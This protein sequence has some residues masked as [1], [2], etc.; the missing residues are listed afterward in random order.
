M[1]VDISDK[2]LDRLKKWESGDMLAVTVDD[3]SDLKSMA[4]FVCNS[5]HSDVKHAERLNEIRSK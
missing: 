1:L 3:W 4:M 2:T 5:L